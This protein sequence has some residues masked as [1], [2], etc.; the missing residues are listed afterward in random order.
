[1]HR[2]RI[3]C[4]PRTRPRGA[5][6]SRKFLRNQSLTHIATKHPAALVIVQGPVTASEFVSQ[7]CA[8]AT[9]RRLNFPVVTRVPKADWTRKG[10]RFRNWGKGRHCVKSARPP[11]NAK[12]TVR[13][14]SANHP[15]TDVMRAATM[16]ATPHSDADGQAFSDLMNRNG[17]PGF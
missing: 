4:I 17:G 1:M 11:K 7:T 10:Q 15:Y 3:C 12:S 16:R 5:R 14:V 8:S 9:R 6:I 13:G 2:K